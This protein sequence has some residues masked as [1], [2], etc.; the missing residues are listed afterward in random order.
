MKEVA[1]AGDVTDRD[2]PGTYA[3]SQ[4]IP[5]VSLVHETITTRDVLDYVDTS[6][7]LALRE[8]TVHVLYPSYGG[9]VGG[10]IDY[11]VPAAGSLFQLGGT[12]IGHVGGRWETRGW[13]HPDQTLL[14]E[15]QPAV[16]KLALTPPDQLFTTLAKPIDASPE[17]AAAESP[18]VTVGYEETA[19]DEAAADWP[20][21]E[22]PAADGPAPDATAIDMTAPSEAE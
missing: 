20:S 22:G 16:K 4:L 12:L 2:L 15:V 11:Y 14:G 10:A 6:S 7:D 8:E 5:G 3:F 13:D 21:G 1:Y 9:S 17:P 19:D 18:V